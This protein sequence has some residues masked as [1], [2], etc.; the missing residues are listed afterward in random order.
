MAAALYLVHCFL[1]L[2]PLGFKVLFV[3]GGFQVFK[4]CF[5]KKAQLHMF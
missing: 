3:L 4:T 5:C 2:N 1:M